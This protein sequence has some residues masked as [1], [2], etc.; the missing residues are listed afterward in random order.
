MPEITSSFTEYAIFI[1][2]LPMLAFPVIL[3]LGRLFNGNETWV[4]SAKEGGLIALP[5]MVASFI[6]SLILIV[7]FMGSGTGSYYIGDWLSFGW[8]GADRKSVV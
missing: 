6:L 1:V 8:I 7:E 4:K 5:I 3:F 2:L